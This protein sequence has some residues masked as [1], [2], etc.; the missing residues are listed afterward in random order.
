MSGYKE[1]YPPEPEDVYGKAVFRAPGRP[2]GKEMYELADDWSYN[3]S[4]PAEAPL[5][6][7]DPK[8]DDKKHTADDKFKSRT[9]RFEIPLDPEL[10]EDDFLKKLKAV[11]KLIKDKKEP[12]SGYENPLEGKI[13]AILQGAG[14]IGGKRTRKTKKHT[15]KHHKKHTKKHNKKH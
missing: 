6:F 14:L 4:G 11:A 9:G 13:A 8:Y 5:D 12:A 2:E 10:T 1:A 7:K 15:K 3:T